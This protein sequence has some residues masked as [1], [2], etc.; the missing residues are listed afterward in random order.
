ML[1]AIVFSLVGIIAGA[2]VWGNHGWAIGG[3][4]GFLLAQLLRLSNQAQD[5]ERQLKLL[6]KQLQ[7]FNTNPPERPTVTAVSPTE[8]A[9]PEIIPEATSAPS[10][11]SSQAI[12]TLTLDLDLPG[13]IPIPPT[14]AAARANNSEQA[15]SGDK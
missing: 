14:P 4:F 8:V 9:A 11:I 15:A 13:E 6:Q 1:V 7:Q 12:E 10:P 5:H 3:L 2:I